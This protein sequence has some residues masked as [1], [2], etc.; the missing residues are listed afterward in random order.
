M[1][2]WSNYTKLSDSLSLSLSFSVLNTWTMSVCV[3]IVAGTVRSFSWHFMEHVYC[4]CSYLMHDV[5]VIISRLQRQNMACTT[6][7][8]IYE[9]EKTECTASF[10]VDRSGGVVVATSVRGCQDIWR[11]S[12]NRLTQ[13]RTEAGIH[14]PWWCAG[15]TSKLPSSHPISVFFCLWLCIQCK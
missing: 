1:V 15:G 8:N 9:Y 2:R 13:Q 14:M 10:T 7:P 6:P 11:V 5:A 4:L 12:F 3:C